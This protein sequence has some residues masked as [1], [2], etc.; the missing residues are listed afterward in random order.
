MEPESPESPPTAG[1]ASARL[2][3]I[4]QLRRI[5]FANLVPFASWLRDRPWNIDLV[6]WFLFFT[7]FPLFMVTWGALTNPK[8]ADVAFIYAIYFST[9]WGVVIYFFIRPEDIRILDL[10][11]VA[12]FTAVVGIFVVG[13]LQQLPVVRSLYGA[14]RGVSLPGRIAG[15]VLGVGVLEE[16]VKAI[17]ILWIFVRNAEPGSTREITFLGCVSGFAFGVSEAVTYSISYVLNVGRGVLGFEDYIVVQ[18]TR[19]I[20]LPLLHAMWAGITAH[21]IALG[22]R[23]PG[24]RRGLVLLGLAIAALLHGL[25]NS[26]SA[27]LLGFLVAIATV[28]VFIAYSRSADSMEQAIQRADDRS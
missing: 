13:L 19:L 6:R 1:E 5:G 14:A 15:F 22:V 9:I 2:G 10:V 26:F 3:A 25:Y 7:L 20:T 16:S 23:H 11:R 27:G 21:F 8:I 28:L 4:R 17:P 18:F 12:L 24:S